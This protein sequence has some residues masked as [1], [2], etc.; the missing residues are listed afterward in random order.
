MKKYVESA[1][2]KEQLAK[3]LR[4]NKRR[5]EGVKE[6]K[7]TTSRRVKEK[8]PSFHYFPSRELLSKLIVQAANNVA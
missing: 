4:P 2:K 3:K 7:K 8:H 5:A 6:A 1:E